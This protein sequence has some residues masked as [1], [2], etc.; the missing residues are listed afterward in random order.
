M[1]THDQTVE[2][3]TAEIGRIVAERQKL[4]AAGASATELEHN[5]QLLAAAQ[6]RLSRLLIQRHL[7]P[8]FAV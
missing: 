2:T 1:D 7:G 4:R 3:L 6:T 8:A 5:R